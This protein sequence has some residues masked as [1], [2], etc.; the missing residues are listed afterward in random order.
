MTSCKM[1][2]RKNTKPSNVKNHKKKLGKNIAERP[3]NI[4]NREEFSDL[5]TDTF[6]GK[7]LKDDCV[8]LT[9]L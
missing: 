8:L 3:S 7:K 1:K 5:E 6:V 4:N 9:I 2:L